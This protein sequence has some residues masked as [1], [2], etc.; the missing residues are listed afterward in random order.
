MGLRNT[1]AG[2][3]A[4]SQTFHWVI[5]AL[6]ATQV[7]LALTAH[8]LPPGIEKLALLARHKSVGI[9]ILLL[10]IARL[11]WRAA[12][13]VPD[14]PSALRPYERA[15]ARFTHFAL[16]AL[17]FAMPLTGWMMSSARGFPVSWFG[18][19]QLPDLVPADRGL[20]DVF[21][22]TH[23][24]LA[25]V[26]GAIVLLHIAGAL[27]HHFVLRDAVLRRMLPFQRRG[28]GDLAS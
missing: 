2:W 1:T 8:D 16:Y 15:L 4:V 18:L 28:S 27:K 21:H 17:L 9:T 24:V 26:L 14:L 13:P 6:V 10:A 22:E 3:G 12:N 11:A 20:Y 23:E 25:R 5:V 19:V 7:A